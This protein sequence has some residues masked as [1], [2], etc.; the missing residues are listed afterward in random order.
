MNR[1]RFALMAASLDPATLAAAGIAC[2]R[3]WGALT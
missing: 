3:L 1:H 2:G